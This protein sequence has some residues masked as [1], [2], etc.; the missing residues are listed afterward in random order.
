M[1]L[2]ESDTIIEL[3]IFDIK[4]AYL[5]FIFI[6]LFHST[7]EFIVRDRFDVVA[8]LKDFE[9]IREP[10][11]DVML[12]GVLDDPNLGQDEAHPG[13]GLKEKTKTSPI[14]DLMEESL[15]NTINLLLFGFVDE[16]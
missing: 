6:D 11:L 14:G 12:L 9:S 7:I 15:L 8:M 3:Y 13:V 4:C 10:V 16:S 1:K 5:S 2:N